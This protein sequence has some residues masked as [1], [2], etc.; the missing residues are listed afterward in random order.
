MISIPT[1]QPDNDLETVLNPIHGKYESIQ[2]YDSRGLSDK[3]MDYHA[4]KPASINDLKEL[5]NS[6]GFWINIKNLDKK[7]FFLYEGTDPVVNQFISLQKGWNLV[8]FPSL[9]NHNRSDGLNNLEFGTEVNAIQ[10][11]DSSTKTWHFLEEGDSFEI[12]RGYWFH[13]KTECVWEVPL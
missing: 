6:M 11:F 13:A 1:N 4:P 5:N 2:Y 8:G 7:T 10:W 3:W 12:G 9:T